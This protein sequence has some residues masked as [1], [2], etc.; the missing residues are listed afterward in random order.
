MSREEVN[1][2]KDYS[3][4]NEESRPMSKTWLDQGSG[5]L[6]ERVPRPGGF[7][8]RLASEWE[9]ESGDRDDMLIDLNG[10]TFS[11]SLCFLWR[12]LESRICSWPPCRLRRGLW[13]EDGICFTSKR[14][15]NKQ[16]DLYRK[17]GQGS[18][19]PYDSHIGLS[20]YVAVSASAVKIPMCLQDR[21]HS[22]R[23][24]SMKQNLS[25]KS[26][27]EVL[28]GRDPPQSFGFL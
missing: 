6:M 3:A 12:E 11:F 17:R 26:V 22:Q 21:I 23:S 2:L 28:K 14:L 15:S 19:L 5:G 7:P 16:E 18:L 20:W 8:W 10:V 13:K 27:W 9:N 24:C 4:R 25:S 1:F